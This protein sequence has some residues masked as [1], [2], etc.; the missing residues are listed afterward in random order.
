[1][2]AID[3]P[4]VYR[5]ALDSVTAGV[6]LVDRN[7]KILFWNSGAER[8]TGYLRQDV[9]GHS[10]LKDF[11]GHL[12][13]DNNQVAGEALPV[14]TVLREGKASIAQVLDPAQVRSS[15]LGAAA[16]GADPGRLWRVDRS[17]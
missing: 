14:S 6:C 8:I 12:D 4:E 1:M 11:L 2:Q 9:V 15:G 10:A 3:D 17:G 5:A 7:G 13:G 16:R